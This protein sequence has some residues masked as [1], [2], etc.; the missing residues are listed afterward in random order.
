MGY[1]RPVKAARALATTYIDFHVATKQGNR[2]AF[3][4][5][6]LMRIEESVGIIVSL[7]STSVQNKID[8]QLTVWI[9]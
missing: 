6:R 3:R 2:E 7:D 4:G 5:R 8:G 9:A 1:T